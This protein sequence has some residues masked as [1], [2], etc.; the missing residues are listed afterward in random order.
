MVHS[1]YSKYCL[2]PVLYIRAV[3]DGTLLTV[4]R[5]LILTGMRMP[6]EKVWQQV[7]CGRL[8]LLSLLVLGLMEYIA[9]GGKCQ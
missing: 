8:L 4:V 5:P 7:V 2:L 9:V 3:N 1:A 6:L